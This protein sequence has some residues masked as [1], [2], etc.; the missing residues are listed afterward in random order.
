MRRET[1]WFH[2]QDGG[3]ILQ[4]LAMIPVIVGLH[5]LGSPARPEAGQHLLVLGIAGQAGLILASVLTFAGMATDMLY[6][7]PAGL[8]GVWLLL[9]NGKQRRIVSG[10]VGWT[11]MVAGFGL[12]L[13]G[14]GFLIYG[15]GVAPAMF[16]RPLTTAEIDAQTLTPANLAAH[17]CMAAGTLLGRLVYPVWTLLLGWTLLRHP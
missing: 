17:I 10:A 8:V 12:V 13:I 15:F 3:V 11:G 7:G 2:W 5:R 1:N 14:L 4:A 9:V 16:L 6:M